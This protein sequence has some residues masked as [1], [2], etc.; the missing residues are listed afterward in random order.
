MKAR[1][2]ESPAKITASE[3]VTDTRHDQR[4]GVTCLV[5]HESFARRVAEEEVTPMNLLKDR[6]KRRQVLDHLTAL[7]QRYDPDGYFG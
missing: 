6:R 2:I 1:T 7:S 5:V 3:E 4:V